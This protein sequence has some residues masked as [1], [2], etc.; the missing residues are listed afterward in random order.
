MGCNGWC[1]CSDHGCH[2][3]QLNDVVSLQRSA[4]W[5]DVSTVCADVA[6][7][8][9]YLGTEHLLRPGVVGVNTGGVFAGG[10]R[11]CSGGKGGV[12]E[13]GALSGRGGPCSREGGRV[14]AR[15]VA[16]DSGVLATG[17]S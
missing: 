8:L 4:A 13:G 14:V 2:I 11:H 5:V 6:V 1:R 16:Q 12:S 7:P 17:N 10:G 15:G 3:H 9:E